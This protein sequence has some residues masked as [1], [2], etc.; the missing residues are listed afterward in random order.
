MGLGWGGLGALATVIE[1]RLGRAVPGGTEALR[2]DASVVLAVVA[3]C[4]LVA[5]A[6]GVVSVAMASRRSL[7][8]CVTRGGRR[9]SESAGAGRVRAA[10]VATQVAL[11]VVLLSG[12]AL[13]VRSAFHLERM[14]LG[15]D[16]TRLEAYTVGLTS[17]GADDLSARAAF[18]DAV[19]RRTTELPGVASVGLIRA[20]PFTGDLT[21][22]RIE[23]EERNAP[24]PLP[25]VVPQII[26]AGGFSVL[27][28]SS[29]EGRLFTD[30]DAP[31][32]A[33]VAVV[34][35]SLGSALAPS[36][37]AVGAR[38]RFSA[39][40]MPDM[41]EEPGPWM[42]I[43]GI[44]PDVADG[45]G[46]VRPTV[47]VPYAQAPSAWMDLL[48]RRRPGSPRLAQEVRTL[49]RDL[50]ENT[51]LYEE[52]DIPDSV[53]RARAPSR[54]LA[55]LLGSFA[56]FSLGLSV[57]GLY[58]VAA[59]AARQRRRDLAVRLALGASRGA[60]ERLFLRDA[61]LTVAVGLAVGVL[62]ARALG[63]AL[64]GQLHGVGAH[65]PATMLAVV[66]G[67]AATA[68][69]AVWIPARGAAR[70]EVSSILREE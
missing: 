14:Q 44:V 39:W 59:Y 31:G 69:L 1:A 51:P 28:L 46:G 36:G 9:G 3:L 52:I 18:F 12:G 7:M 34:S 25:E 41:E 15:F 50:D 42:S 58:G 56:L 6:L 27:D 10:L 67:V 68:L 70:L 65:D 33:P 62:G 43:V 4:G 26:S 24:E 16:P 60:V 20:V 8:R 55:A 11:S 5:F 17:E 63:G 61:A 32:G 30:E 21:A 54:F 48:I 29:L 40:T 35:A 2:L 57:V 49:V 23:V 22:R 45:I 13:L 38:I 66:V 19:L 53:R 64:R 37:G 47:Y